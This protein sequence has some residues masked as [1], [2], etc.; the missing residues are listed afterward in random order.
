MGYKI[1]KDNVHT[2]PN[3]KEWDK[4]GKEFNNYKGGKHK[5]RVCDDDGNPYFYGF[6]D[7]SSSFDP[8]DRLGAAYGCT[9][10]EYRNEETKK[11]EVL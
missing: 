7:D 11:Y 4:K 8:L 9:Y 1:T 3:D 2:S 5:F 6:E 10:I